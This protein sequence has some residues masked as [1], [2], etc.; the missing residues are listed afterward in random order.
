MLCSFVAEIFFAVNSEDA[1]TLGV[2]QRRGGNYGEKDRRKTE[3]IPMERRLKRLSFFVVFVA[4]REK[5]GY[6]IIIYG[7]FRQ[8]ATP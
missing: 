4:K 7:D 3:S 2:L 8:E 1:A 5:M 6:T